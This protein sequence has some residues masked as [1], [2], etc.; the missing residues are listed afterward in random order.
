MVAVT[1][2][3]VAL[4]AVKEGILPDPLAPN[5]ILVLLLAQL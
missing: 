1:V 5:P 2:A 4:L 3:L